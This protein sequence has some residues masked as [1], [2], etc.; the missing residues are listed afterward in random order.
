MITLRL[1]SAFA[2][3][4]TSVPNTEDVTLTPYTIDPAQTND[5][6]ALARST[7][8]APGCWWLAVKIGQALL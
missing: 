2:D 4:Y 5:S 3:T 8:F 6:S 1:T 7:S